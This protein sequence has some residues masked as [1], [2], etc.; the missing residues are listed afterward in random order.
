MCSLLISLLHIFT[1]FTS[2][3]NH[4]SL[5]HTMSNNLPAPGSPGFDPLLARLHAQSVQQVNYDRERSSAPSTVS[6]R[7]PHSVHGYTSLNGDPPSFVD[8]V[9]YTVAVCPVKHQYA[10]SVA[11]P[12]THEEFCAYLE[13]NDDDHKVDPP[14]RHPLSQETGCGS[15]AKT[16]CAM[17]KERMNGTEALTGA[18]TN[19][20]PDDEAAP[21]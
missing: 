1:A 13:G 21:Q 19:A 11:P 12:M 6:I 5:L 10:V 7:T 9:G 17:L 8:M 20:A 15:F 18:G 4:Q 16:S 14:E 3:S 2:T